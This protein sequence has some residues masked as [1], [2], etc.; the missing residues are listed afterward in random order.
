MDTGSTDRQQ[1]QHASAPLSDVLA[2]A[3]LFL[4]TVAVAAGFARVFTGWDFLDELILVALVGHGAS[5]VLRLLRA[6]VWFAFPLT[7]LAL[8][9][10]ISMIFY[11][12]SMTLLVP[13]VGD[14]RPCSGSTSTAVGEA[15]R[16]EVAPVPFDVGWDVLAAIGIAAA[17]LLS[18]TFAFRAFARAEA[19]VPGGR[20]VRVRGGARQPIGSGSHSTMMLVGR[21]CGHHH[22]AASPSRHRFRPP[23]RSRPTPLRSCR[24]APHSC[25][26]SP[27][28]SSP[29][30][31]GPDCRV[32]VPRRCTTPRGTVAAA[33]PRSSA[34]SST[35]G[36][37]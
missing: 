8:V 36:R 22:R 10:T 9:S 19:L 26:H 27:S 5:L 7:L 37:V 23:D 3:T 33:S 13:H 29:E 30:P 4:F 1:G 12:E 16:T 20:A 35:S 6:P 21:R 15:F 17:V 18:D 2:S 14:H 11:R 28:R 24:P 25:R 34:R 32:P 31:S